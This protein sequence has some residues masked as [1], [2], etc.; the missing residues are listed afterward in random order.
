M[1]N[2]KTTALAVVAWIA[3]TG[4]GIGQEDKSPLVLLSTGGPNDTVTRDTVVTPFTK[5]TGIEVI[6]RPQSDAMISAVVAQKNN[7]QYDLILTGY[8]SYI[9]LQQ[10]D[11]LDRVN[12]EEIPNAAT[13]YPLARSTHAIGTS[14]TGVTLVYNTEKIRTPPTSWAA[15]WNPA[16]KGH[17]IIPVVPITYGLDFLVMTARTFGGS[18]H[19]IDVGFEKLKELAPNVSGIYETSSN[20]AQMFQLGG[21]WIA[22]WFA[23]RVPPTRAAGVPVAAAKL[24]EGQ[25]AYVT[26][27][28]P[29]KGRYSRKVAQ[30]MNMY[31]ATD[32]QV[33]FAKGVG[34]GPAR[35]DVVLDPALAATV[36]YGAEQINELVQLDWYTIV[37]KRGEWTDRFRRE[38]VPFV[39]KK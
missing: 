9:Y 38:I 36:P 8:D 27:L 11:V 25:V 33:A 34:Q 21:A 16:F 14:F 7:P 37:R 24:K 5:A 10:N 15:I 4:P 13:L 22:P 31:L 30:F 26:M 23:G 2:I 39:G 1:T 20:A 32:A 12:H 17:V 3:G 18:E 29:L 35:W 19:N 6:I 28:A